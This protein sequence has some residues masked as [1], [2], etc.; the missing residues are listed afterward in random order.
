LFAPV[1]VTLRG[2]G[3]EEAVQAV[4]TAGM[5]LVPFTWRTR[6]EVEALG[7]GPPLIAEAGALVALDSGE[8]L[9]GPGQHA[10]RGQLLAAAH[11]CGASLRFLVDMQ[12][13]ELQSVTGLDAKG[14]RLARARRR[15]DPFVV[16]RGSVDDLVR[17][18]AASGLSV[19]D[20]G[21]FLQAQ[22]PEGGYG[23]AVRLMA[24]LLSETADYGV[25]IGVADGAQH[26]AVL[27]AV[28]VPVLLA[29]GDGTYDAEILAAIPDITRVQAAG[30]LGLSKVARDALA[31]GRADG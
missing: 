30:P 31:A 21:P 28:D 4:R 2:A 5:R 26:L 27:Q 22:A 10:L 15:S 20:S 19:R 17:Q 8:R 6:A 11:D 18:L 1:D 13:A 23:P 16:T 3:A 24:Q 9:L 12:D 14:R 29:R 7:L 25:V